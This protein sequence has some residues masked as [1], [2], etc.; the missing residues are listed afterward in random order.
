MKKQNEPTSG[1]GAILAEAF[2]L[3]GPPV[4]YIVA[5][6]VT[7]EQRTLFI[8]PIVRIVIVLAI[9][10]SIIV[11]F[12]ATR[13]APRALLLL[14]AVFVPNAFVLEDVVFIKIMSIF[15]FLFVVAVVLWGAHSRQPFLKT[16]FGEIL[17]LPRRTWVILTRLC[18]AAYVVFAVL[19]EITWRTVSESTW[20][21]AKRAPI[22]LVYVGLIVI[23]VMSIRSSRQLPPIGRLGNGD[24]DGRRATFID[25]WM[26]LF[27]YSGLHVAPVAI[28]CL[29][30]NMASGNPAH[31]GPFALVAAVAVVGLAAHSIICW[32]HRGVGAGMYSLLAA[33][34]AIAG[35][36]GSSAA[37]YLLID[38]QGEGWERDGLFLISASTLSIYIFLASASLFVWLAGRRWGRLRYSKQAGPPAH[39]Y[40]SFAEAFEARFG[41]AKTKTWLNRGH[42]AAGTIIA[43]GWACLVT[44][45]VAPSQPAGGIR[46][47]LTYSG[48]V[49]GVL[50]FFAS[51]VA[52]RHNPADPDAS[53]RGTVLLLRPFQE[54]T[55]S[56]GLFAPS[57]ETHI[58]NLLSPYLTLVAIKSP[59]RLETFGA[60]H[61]AYGHDV[62]QTEALRMM[63]EAKLIILSLGETPG[64]QWEIESILSE[65]FCGKTIFVVPEPS[66]NQKEWWK[67]STSG[68]RDT[69][70]ATEVET[71]GDLAS[72]A[73]AFILQGDGSIRVV[74]I[75]EQS[76]K[77]RT[78]GVVLAA[79]Q[80]LASPSQV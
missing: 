79:N 45:L 66:G 15:N 5:S 63:R 44:P 75:G 46:I 62:W 68:F 14:L 36:V 65:D 74:H 78:I 29:G 6:L 51:H 35:S 34:S 67:C 40:A 22:M 20:V 28:G 39:I 33:Q 57:F 10:A 54:D 12:A 2:A 69:I 41:K 21:N 77:S 7:P 42:V 76:H 38:R 17:P 11:S 24:L 58:A 26:L 64:V 1:R 18:V 8:D 4:V 27:T 25:R 72:S 71:L 61:V 73:R 31:P 80:L 48:L 32:R 3:A 30:V 43:L 9:L 55:D 37:L 53:R 23:I 50:L 70:W 47:L 16:V 19:N 60:S 59:E 56:T 52:M 49:G 13:R